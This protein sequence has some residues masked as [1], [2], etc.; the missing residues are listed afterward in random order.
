[1]SDLKTE[2]SKGEALHLN[3]TGVTQEP[4]NKMFRDG[5]SSNGVEK[6]SPPRA[7]FIDRNLSIP[8]T[9]CN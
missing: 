9:S 7:T 4:V 2:E 5:D 1:M 3:N 6:R 8:Q